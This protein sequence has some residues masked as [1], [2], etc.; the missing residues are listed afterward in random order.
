MADVPEH[1]PVSNYDALRRL[2][3]P[4]MAAFLTLVADSG[5]VDYEKNLC[6]L[7]KPYEEAGTG[8]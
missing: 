3:V 5:P 4:S 6:W 8:A 2:D 1:G 7:L